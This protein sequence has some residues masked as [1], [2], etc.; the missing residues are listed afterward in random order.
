MHHCV[1]IMQPID[2]SDESLFKKS[3]IQVKQPAKPERP[4]TAQMDDLELCNQ[5]YGTNDFKCKGS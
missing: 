4:C 1:I 2:Y 3:T 5:L